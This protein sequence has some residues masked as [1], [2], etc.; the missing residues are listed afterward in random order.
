MV[1]VINSHNEI[2]LDKQKDQHLVSTFTDTVFLFETVR[3]NSF[4]FFLMCV[5]TVVVVVM[6]T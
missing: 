1:P 3:R 6:V 2:S 5:V 4:S